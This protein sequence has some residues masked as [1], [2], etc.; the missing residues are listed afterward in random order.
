M[1][2]QKLTDTKIRIIFNLEDMSSNNFSAE[3]FFSDNSISQKIL[4]SI[5]LMAEKEVGFKTDDCKLLVE[6]ISCND[7]E[8]VFTITKLISHELSINSSTFI[9]KFKSFDDVLSLC[10]Y[11]KN[12]NINNLHGFFMNCSLFAYNNTYYLYINNDFDLPYLLINTF[13]EF[14]TYIPYNSKFDGILNEYGKII[15]DKNAFSKCM[16]FV[17]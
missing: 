3:T 16:E 9:F 8:F 17:N 12:M 13:S 11:I 1:K 7:G 2:F 5:L 10:T 6:A 15:F 14:G 4:H